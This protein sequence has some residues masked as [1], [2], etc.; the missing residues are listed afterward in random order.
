M[1]YIYVYFKRQTHWLEQNTKLREIE[2]KTI[3][4]WPNPDLNRREKNE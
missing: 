4:S 1:I 3:Y 2:K